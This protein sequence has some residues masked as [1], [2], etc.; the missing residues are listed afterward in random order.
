MT[1][2]Q[3]LINQKEAQIQWRKLIEAGSHSLA[4]DL[5]AQQLDLLVSYIEQLLKWN[6]AYNLTA[7]H[8]PLDMIKLHIFDSLAIIECLAKLNA[9]RFIDIGTGAGLPGMVLAIVCPQKIVHLLDTNGKKTRF[10]THFKHLHQLNIKDMLN[11]CQQLVT[12]NGFFVAMK[13]IYPAA[14]LDAMP[15]NYCLLDCDVLQVPGVDA[16]RHLI[17]IQKQPT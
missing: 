2:R 17:T 7:V 12:L 3:S 6:R 15:A 10:L 11:G 16:K 5:T 14:E 9:N 13:G 8:D 4:I 1:S